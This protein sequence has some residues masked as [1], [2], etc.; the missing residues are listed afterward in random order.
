MRLPDDTI[1]K[2]QAAIPWKASCLGWIPGRFWM[3]F[4]YVRSPDDEFVHEIVHEPVH[5]FVHEFDHD[6][7]NEPAIGG[8]KWNLSKWSF[9]SW[10]RTWFQ[11]FH[12]PNIM[13]RTCSERS[14]LLF[15]PKRALTGCPQDLKYEKSDIFENCL[16]FSFSKNRI[17]Q[18]AISTIS[19]R[20]KIQI[21]IIHE[22]ISEH[23]PNILFGTVFSAN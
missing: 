4:K 7:Q 10:P 8:S 3:S 23:V 20:P 17:L 15:P 1:A 5:E 21:P 22:N 13:F 18:I 2:H 11:R 19:M 16:H 6:R 14:G 9:L 12:V